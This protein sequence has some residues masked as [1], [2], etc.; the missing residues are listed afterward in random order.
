[1]GGR[2]EDRLETRDGKIVKNFFLTGLTG[3]S[4]WVDEEL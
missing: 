3:F 4:G 1:M 2:G